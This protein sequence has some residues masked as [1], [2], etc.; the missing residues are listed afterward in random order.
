MTEVAV[1]FDSLPLMRKLNF[2]VPERADKLSKIASNSDVTGII[3][4]VSIPIIHLI[5][6]N[7]HPTPGLSVLMRSQ[8]GYATNKCKSHCSTPRRA[9]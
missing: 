3:N 4:G 8:V 7:A 1:A 2:P 6:L 5:S 9:K